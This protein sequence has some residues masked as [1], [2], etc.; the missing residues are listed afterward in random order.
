[1]DMGR[2]IG[3][4][5]GSNFLTENRA[6]VQGSQTRDIDKDFLKKRLNFLKK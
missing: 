5:Q 6:G 2:D 4:R 3:E 1:M